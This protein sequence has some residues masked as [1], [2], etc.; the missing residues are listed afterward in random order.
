MYK[1]KREY[2]I[3]GAFYGAC[4]LVGLAIGYFWW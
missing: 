4:I 2:F 3:N 1:T